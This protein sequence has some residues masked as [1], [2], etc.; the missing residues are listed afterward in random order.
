MRLKRNL[1]KF[2]EKGE[3]YKLPPYLEDCLSFNLLIKNLRFLFLTAFCFAINLNFY[4]V[5]FTL[6]SP[7]QFYFC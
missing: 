1:F 4:N 5:L 7:P 3:N 6:V 2:P